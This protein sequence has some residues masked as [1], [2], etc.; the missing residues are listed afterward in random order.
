MNPMRFLC[1]MLVAVVII[2]SLSIQASADDKEIHLLCTTLPIYIFAANVIGDIPNF[3]L[4]LL[5]DPQS[6]DIHDY[7][8]SASDMT[9]LTQADL[10]FM[11]GL[12]LELPYE[13]TLRKTVP[14]EKLVDTS[15]G[16]EPIRA[17]HKH[18][19][20]NDHIQTAL[21]P[22][23]WLSPLKAITQVQNITKKLCHDYPQFKAQLSRNS[24]A[25]QQE[26]LKLHQSYK[27]VADAAPN[28]KII[29]QHNSIDY[30][31]RDTNLELISSLQFDESD[32]PSPR[33]L[34]A[35][36]KLAKEKKPAVM[37]ID[38]YISGDYAEL[39]KKQTGIPVVIF[40]P[41]AVGK[42]EKNYYTKVMYKN[43]EA[44][45]TALG[46]ADVIE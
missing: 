31:A 30:L 32:I 13:P 44:L 4:E 19:S 2:S 36:I 12:T 14:E 34:D 8:L 7:Y 24:Q 16:I 29:A 26:L 10:V 3:T 39:V 42:P 6:G 17:S 21:N 41:V 1:L 45:K 33:E 25:Y 9:K 37:L 35:F 40:D 43:L 22:H 38:P 23:C 27:K 20:G 18:T 28:R 15:R 11:N 46:V 5:L